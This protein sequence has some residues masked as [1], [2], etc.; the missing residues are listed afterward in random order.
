MRECSQQAQ[1]LV[2]DAR[3]QVRIVVQ[4]HSDHMGPCE[5]KRCVRD[6]PALHGMILNL[7]QAKQK[8]RVFDADQPPHATAMQMTMSPKNKPPAGSLQT[9]LVPSTDPDQV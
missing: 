1:H 6:V 5:S 8:T 2:D 4:I 9:R 7:L 3:H